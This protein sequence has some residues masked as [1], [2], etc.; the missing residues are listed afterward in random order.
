MLSF[1]FTKLELGNIYKKPGIKPG[2]ELYYSEIL[3]A[4]L[5]SNATKYQLQPRDRKNIAPLKWK[6]MPPNQKLCPK[7]KCTLAIETPFGFDQG[8]THSKRHSDSTYSLT[9]AVKYG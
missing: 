7:L 2:S 5:V 1:K 6:S 3:Y 8:N 4:L 9:N